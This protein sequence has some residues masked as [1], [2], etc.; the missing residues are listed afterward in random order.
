MAIAVSLGSAGVGRTAATQTRRWSLS[1]RLWI[2]VRVYCWKLIISHIVGCS[3]GSRKELFY[4]TE[5]EEGAPPGSFIF[6]G[7]LSRRFDTTRGGGPRR[8]FRTCTAASR[9]AGHGRV[10]AARASGGRLRR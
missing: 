9:R 8:G 5:Y 10:A 1:V 7:G 4:G 6:G 3:R 2:I